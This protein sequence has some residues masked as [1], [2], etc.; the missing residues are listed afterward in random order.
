MVRSLFLSA[1]MIGVSA[2]TTS[3]PSEVPVPVAEEP[4][5]VDPWGP[6]TALLGSR[7]ESG[8]APHYASSEGWKRESD[9][10]LV[11]AGYAIRGRDTVLVEDLKLERLA[12][13]VV[14]SARTRSGTPGEW[15]PFTAQ[16]GSD[17]S[18]V[19]ENPGHDFPQCIMYMIDTVDSSILVEVS[20]MENG[21][22]RTERIHLTP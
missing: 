18:L 17:D 13:R 10:V 2:C 14:L 12:D 6:Y 20:G 11:G 15:V 3:T 4:R 16:A 7:A 22:E 1:L 21:L 8:H 19:F 5:A 9:S